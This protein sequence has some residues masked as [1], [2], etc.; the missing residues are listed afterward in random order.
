MQTRSGQ[1]PGR[2]IHFRQV[3]SGQANAGKSGQDHFRQVG[4]GQAN[5][6]KIW[7]GVRKDSHFRQAGK[8]E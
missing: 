1:E 8:Q 5:A 7:A 2:Y 4:S 6:G 3:G